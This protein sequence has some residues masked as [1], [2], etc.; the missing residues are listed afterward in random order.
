MHATKANTYCMG[1]NLCGLDSSTKFNSSQY[2]QLY[3]IYLN[4]YKLACMDP[5]C[6]QPFEVSCKHASITGTTYNMDWNAVFK[7]CK[8]TEYSN[9]CVGALIC[10]SF[11]SMFVLFF[12]YCVS[13]HGGGIAK[14]NAYYV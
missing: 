11:E 2:F 12:L 1:Y 10:V 9:Y 8:G 5:A 13:T 4:E 3:G 14:F 6:G 7:T